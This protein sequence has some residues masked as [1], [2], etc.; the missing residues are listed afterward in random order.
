[1][2]LLLNFRIQMLL[3]IL[4]KFSEV[5]M[6]I[7]LTDKTVLITGASRGIGKAMALKFAKANAT[8][9]LHYHKNLKAAHETL[10][11]LKQGRHFVV[12]ADLAD[13]GSIQKMMATV[14][15]QF[16]HITI[17]INNAGIFQ[18]API[19]D[20]TYESWQEVWHRTI[21]TNL[22]G[23]ANLTFLVAQ[24]M[25]D[26]GG[27]KIINISSRG[28]FRGEPDAPSYGASKAGLNAMSQSLAQAL[29]PYKIFVYVI[30]PGFVET[31]MARPALTGVSGDAIRQQSPLHRVA[32][33]D[34]VANTALFLAS[35]GID[36]LTGGIIDV[37]GAS[38]LRS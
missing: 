31:E 3:K 26:H 5:K 30:A 13:P 6:T 2:M 15:S 35:E 19:T 24:N 17:L 12:Q 37:N 23:P 32:F 25:I 10:A 38:Y 33:P 7:D 20:S 29:A 21:Q 34:E 28:A 18:D 16:S 36:F 9:I 27:G 8:I 11:L 14:L 22:M 1:M 4:H